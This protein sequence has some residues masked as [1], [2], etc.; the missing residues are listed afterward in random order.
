MFG[1]KAQIICDEVIISFLKDDIDS[2]IVVG[3]LYNSYN[4]AL[5]KLPQNHHQTTLSSKTIGKDESGKNELTLSNLKDKEQIYLKAQKDYD[6]IINH[7]FTQKILNNKD[8]ITD[9][10][11]TQRVK[12]AHFQTIDLAKNVVVGAEYLTTVGASRDTIVGISNTLNVG[13]NNKL[14]VAKDSSEYIGANK[15]VEI[16]GNLESEIKQD[17]LRVVKGNKKEI[18]DGS[19]DIKTKREFNLSSE[20]Q[21]NFNSTDNILYEANRSISF[22][23]NEAISFKSQRAD[24]LSNSLFSAEAKTEIIN[25]V[26]NSLISIKDDKII[27]RAGGVEVIIDSSGLTVIGGEIKGE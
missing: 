1:N 5:P 22:N 23:S 21:I 3:N 9:G 27:L 15:S 6:E 13:L 14:R 8:S 2:M 25:S 18:V 16:D 17:E 10:N 11:Y 12:K 4:P 24:L 26:K 19:S 20:A 7:N